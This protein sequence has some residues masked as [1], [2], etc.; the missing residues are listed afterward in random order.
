MSN[1]KK[2]D[3]IFGQNNKSEVLNSLPYGDPSTNK[4]TEKD[5]KGSATHG[6]KEVVYLLM[7]LLIPQ[8]LFCIYTS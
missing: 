7:L 2:L 1:S 8:K 5:F 3:V 4:E 6:A